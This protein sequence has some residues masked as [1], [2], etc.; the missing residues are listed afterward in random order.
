MKGA[1][2]HRRSGASR[3]SIPPIAPR[4]THASLI[5]YYNRTMARPFKWTYKPLKE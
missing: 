4:R 1:E 5:E 3:R 2:F